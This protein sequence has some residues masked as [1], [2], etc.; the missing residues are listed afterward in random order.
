MSPILKRIMQLLILV[1]LQTTLLFGSAGDLRWSA[2]WWYIGLYVLMLVGA[3][4]ILIPGHKEVI[5]ER[6]KGV[7][8]GRRWDHLITQAMILPTLGTLLLAGFD[9]RWNWVGSMPTWLRI[10]G[11]VLFAAGYVLTLWAM[12]ANP[13]FSQTVRIQSERGHKAINSGPYHFVRHPG[14]LGMTTSLLGAVFLLG[15]FWCF[16][17]FG[18]YIVLILI[19]TSLEDR[20]LMAEL[21]GYREYASHTRFR[22]ISGLW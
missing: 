15:S 7:K 19:R 18:I 12:S 3:S 20:T 9:E 2:G 22:L 5:E 4:V 16:I 11:G 10:L 13:F 17:C 21:P 14:Y 6:S 8:G 1:L